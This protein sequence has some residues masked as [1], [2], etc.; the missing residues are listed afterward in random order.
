MLQ[1]DYGS[2]AMVNSIEKPSELVADASHEIVADFSMESFSSKKE[3]TLVEKAKR[4]DALTNSYWQNVYQNLFAGCSKILA[5]ENQRSRLA[6]HL[7]DC[8]QK[9]TG[10]SPLPYCDVKTTMRNCLSRLDSND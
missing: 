10:R 6:C 8:F 4:K 7:S 3:M 2:R 5:K 9:E 1:E